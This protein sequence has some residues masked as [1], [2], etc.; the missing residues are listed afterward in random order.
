MKRKLSEKT[1]NLIADSL[2]ATLFSVSFT[3]AGLRFSG[4]DTPL[5]SFLLISA[6]WL[7]LFS[8]LSRRW[9]LAPLTI[10][11][12]PMILIILVWRLDV[13]SPV[14]Q[15][16]DAFY[17]TSWLYL[18]SGIRMESGQWLLHTVI[19]LPVCLL[20]FLLVRLISSIYFFLILTT[21][22]YLPLL[23]IRPDAWPP[24]LIALAA[25]LI[26]MPRHFSLMIER[27]RPRDTRLPRAPMQMLAI[28]V[29]ILSLLLAQTIVP[30]DTMKWRWP[31]LAERLRDLE[32]LWRGATGSQRN[33]PFFGLDR[34]GYPAV[35]GT[36][37]GPVELSDQLVLRVRTDKPVLL[38]GSSYS[39]YTGSSWQSPDLAGYRFSSPIW[40]SFRRQAWT[41]TL[42]SDR[43][44]EAIR[45]TFGHP[46]QLE[47]E[48]GQAMSHLFSAGR[49]QNIQTENDL[50]NPPYFK[51][52]SDLYVYE[53][54]SRFTEYSIETEYYDRY[55]NGFPEAMH[56]LAA[57]QAPLQD[58][59]LPEIRTLY[60]QL[61]ESLP[62]SVSEQALQIVG[63]AET[64]FAKANALEA[65]FKENGLYQL[66]PDPVPEGQDFVEHVLE[67]QTGYCVYFAT[68]MVVMARTLDIPARYVEGFYLEK[69]ADSS[70]YEARGYTAHAWAELYFAGFGWLPFDATPAAALPDIPDDPIDQPVS[71]TPFISPP[72]DITPPGTDRPDGQGQGRLLLLILLLVIAV[73][74]LLRFLISLAYRRHR[75]RI[76]PENV[77]LRWPDPRR[78]LEFYYRDLLHQLS[79]L[80]I[81]PEAGE[82]LRRFAVRADSFIRLPTLRL[83]NILETVGR[84]R[85]GQIV[86]DETE[87]LQIATLHDH[88]ERRLR[89]SLSAPHY[90]FRRVLRRMR[91]LD[92]QSRI[93]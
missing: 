40:R 12:L 60:L 48:T 90:F 61:P 1:G 28:P 54:M 5:F 34:Y 15:A 71:P 27:E 6:G 31:P 56:E 21:A 18:Q 43:Q 30:D 13:W 14:R 76:L 25:L 65:Y 75:N 66:N 4:L 33:Q 2:V 55:Q 32:D 67:T 77:H 11:S 19:L 68:A 50:D 45:Q 86:P 58:R 49:V 85:Y 24:L 84:W 39:L 70:Y 38:R 20:F 47:I 53:R 83:A 88:L 87:I 42:P 51:V 62:T 92:I 63:D 89:Q 82:T 23:V 36:L 29:V 22:L 8:L 74:L 80:K 16:V 10:V 37:G 17:Q 9:W 52:S 3:A 41:Q 93:K 7:I 78:R 26:L 72:T 44:G 35:T 64:A 81:E 57:S 46:L 73:P 79:C 69:Q 91:P 59:Y